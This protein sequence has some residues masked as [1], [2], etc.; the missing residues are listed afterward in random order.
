MKIIFYLFDDFET[1]DLFGPVEVLCR[2][3]DAEVEYCSCNGG[4]IFSAQ[5]TSINTKKLDDSVKDSIFLIPGGR[6]T[7]SLVKNETEKN[8]IKKA[9]ELCRW[10]LSVCTGSAV[11]ASCGILDGKTATSNKKAFDWVCSC[12]TKVLWQKT[13]RFCK[14]GKFYTSAGVSAGI[15]MSFEFIKDNYGIELAHQITC[16]IEYEKN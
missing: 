14:D 15:D 16:D 11:L 3:P 4:I 7:R 2:I 10:C 13:P 12:S 8:T 6:G 5:K 9:C 1:L